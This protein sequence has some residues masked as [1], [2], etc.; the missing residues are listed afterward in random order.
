MCWGSGG[1]PLKETC[2]V[3]VLETKKLCFMCVSLSGHLR[4]V[5]LI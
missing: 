5:E 4:V 1:G 3:F 2:L